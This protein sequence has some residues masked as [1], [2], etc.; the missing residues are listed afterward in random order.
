[1]ASMEKFSQGAVLNQIRHIQRT[2][3]NPSNEDINKE[4]ISKDYSLINDR[5]MSAY[6]YFKERKSQLYCYG[7]DDVKVLAGWVIT[8]PTDVPTELH[9]LF[10]YNVFDFLCERY[11]AENC[12]ECTVHKD[13]SGQPHMHFLFIPV[14]KDKKHGGEKIC[15]N[16]VLNKRELRNFHPDLQNYLKNNGCPG[17]VMT[18]I[19]K[20]QGGN[21]TVAELKKERALQQETKIESRWI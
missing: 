11:G 8:C 6:D 14:V 9:D 12:I 18:G 13:E 2:I 4:L 16:D 15:A 1:M 21:R 19:T 20:K 17:T 3:Q 7:R 5:G 10:F